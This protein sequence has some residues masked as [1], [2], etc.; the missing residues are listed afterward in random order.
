MDYISSHLE[1]D[2]PEKP[3]DAVELPNTLRAQKHTSVGL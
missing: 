3:I 2:E 1:G